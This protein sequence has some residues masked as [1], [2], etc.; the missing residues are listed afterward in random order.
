MVLALEVAVLK[1]DLKDPNLIIA[2]A[3]L[4]G[5]FGRVRVGDMRRCAVEPEAD[6]AAD[7]QFGYLE[8][9]FME[10]KTARPGTSKALPIAA[11]AFGLCATA[12]WAT[13]WLQ[14]RATQSLDAARQLTLLPAMADQGWHDA[15]YTTPEF[16]AAL[17]TT[18]LQ[19]DFTAK[20]LEGIGSHSLKATCLSWVAK[21]GVCREHRRILGYH[22]DI[23]ERSAETYAKG[24]GQYF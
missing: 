7:K 16:A 12:S 24:Q 3:A 1:A 10:H 11:P 9:R 15:A 2:G 14:A 13:R 4:L 21:F 17:R 6:M 20:G 5:V 18:L 8:T 19:L 23:S 22:V